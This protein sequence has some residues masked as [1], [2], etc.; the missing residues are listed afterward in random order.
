MDNK[1]YQAWA[2]TK[3]RKY[4]NNTER[5]IHGALG[6][7]GEVGELV[8]IIKKHVMY[9]KELDKQH[10]KEELGDALWYFSIVLDEVGSSFGEVMQINY[11]KLEKRYPNGYTSA[12]AIARADKK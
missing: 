2:L 5:L 3:D 4:S 8:D 1:S 7:A 11:E 12:D 10:I 6:S 9:G